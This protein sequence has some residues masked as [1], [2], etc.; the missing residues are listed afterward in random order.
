[1]LKRTLPILLVL[2][3]FLVA[4]PTSTGAQG[5]SAWRL[6]MFDDATQTL[7][8][9]TPAGVQVGPS[10]PQMASFDYVGG[11][12]VSPNG[13]FMVFAGSQNQQ[14][15][16]FAANLETQTCCTPL[17]NPLFAAADVNLV[18]PFS[19]DG[20]QIVIAQGNTSTFWQQNAAPDTLITVLDLNSGALV[21]S[22]PV[23]NLQ[24]DEYGMVALFGDWR[25]D[26]IRLLPS[27]WACEG[28]WEGSFQIWDPYS[29]ALSGPSEYFYILREDLPA[30]G[31]QIASIANPNFPNTGMPQAYFAPANVIEYYPT[32]DSAGTP[33]FFDPDMPYISRSD[34][35][36]D[37]NAILIRQPG[38]FFWNPDFP[39]DL[40]EFSP[41]DSY[42]LLLR[43]GQ[44][45]LLEPNQGNYVYGTPDGWL[46]R[47]LVTNEL[48]HN[49]LL[50]GGQVT[51]TTLG[52]AQDARV[53]GQNYELGQTASGSFPAVAPPATITC[54]GFMPSR[55]APNTLA[56]VTPGPANNLRDLP[57]LNAGN[58]IG[59]IPGNGV[60]IVLSGPD[61]LE[62]MA[63]WQVDYQGQ[64]GWTS[65]GQGNE[66]WLVPVYD[67]FGF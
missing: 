56:A 2:A 19:Q 5:S 20:T 17:G 13:R 23:A 28:A 11:V 1:M 15:Q 66:Y 36:A 24:R 61:C 59:S 10:F 22:I 35:V 58:V 49:V 50:P 42:H 54:P 30:T 27:C 34:F 4:F 12:R 67:M 47:N 25:T 52:Q 63:W 26:G 43:S 38:W 64:V 6:A 16:I 29:G 37:G 46:S 40:P 57:G 44:Q 3:L 60:F 31:E 8:W 51:S 55:L 32:R 9:V 65:E 18:G 39:S 45:V 21:N 7:Y 41:N 62:N 53:V 14:E 33:I 48:I